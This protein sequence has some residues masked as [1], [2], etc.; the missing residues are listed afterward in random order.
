MKQLI[1]VI[2]PTFNEEANVARC[3]A[4]VRDI[5]QA[6]LPDCALEHI[7]SDNASNDRTVEILREIC[8]GDSNVR[9]IVNRRNF[10]AERSMLNA[11]RAARGNAVVVLLPADLQ[12]PVEMIPKF[13]LEWRKGTKIVYGVRRGRRESFALKACRKIFYRAVN[14]MAE[15]P[16]PRDVGEFQLIDREV[17]EVLREFD[18]RRPYLRGMIASCGFPGIG[19][20]YTVAE[21]KSG[22]SSMNFYRLVDIALNGLTSF[23]V[24]PMRLILAAGIIIAT[25]ALAYSIISFLVT[26]IWFREFAQPG[27]ATLIVGLFFFGGIQLFFLGVL[28]EY[29]L[30]IHAQVRQRPLVIEAERIN[31]KTDSGNS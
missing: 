24:V 10:G 18:D 6:E 28:G 14:R 1:T 31:F 30:S 27:I 15:F 5:F 22:R 26:L 8:A 23:S 4:A 25:L 19:I 21:R 9:A 11:L 7:F 13:V 20:E 16:I 2:T 12:D 29:I 17:V 3:H